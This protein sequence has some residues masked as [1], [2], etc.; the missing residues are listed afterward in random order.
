MNGLK[1]D[2]A[3]L[4]E[5]AA[6]HTQSDSPFL[7]TPAS[8]PSFLVLASACLRRAGRPM[9]VFTASRLQSTCGGRLTPNFLCPQAFDTDNSRSLDAGEFAAAA[10]AEEAKV[11][12][13]AESRGSDKASTVVSVQDLAHVST[14]QAREYDCI[15]HLCAT[16]LVLFKVRVD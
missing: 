9:G 3:G 8:L 13:G 15:A 7:S 11:G 4:D 2:S 16:V 6:R 5:A 12:A 1:K 10:K 14:L